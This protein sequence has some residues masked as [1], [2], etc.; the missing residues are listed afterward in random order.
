V[1]SPMADAGIEVPFSSPQ[2]A[3]GAALAGRI[4]VATAT[5]NRKQRVR[6]SRLMVGTN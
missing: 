2:V 3:A 4:A 5:R 1:G 6:S